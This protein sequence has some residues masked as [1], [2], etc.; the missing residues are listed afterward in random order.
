MHIF[1][2]ST[3]RTKRVRD[4]IFGW[5]YDGDL[6]DLDDP[7]KDQLCKALLLDNP[8]YMDD[9][10]PAM[11]DD[12]S[13]WVEM[14]YGYY[15]TSDLIDEYRNAVYSEV[16]A[17]LEDMVNWAQADLFDIKPEPFQGYGRGE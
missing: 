12:N 3:Q 1:S 5:G 15:V 9:I 6:I 11:I 16:E 7:Q 14:L 8:E 10:V 4:L 17:A 13:E 2:F